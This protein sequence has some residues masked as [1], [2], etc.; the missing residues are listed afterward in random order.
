M[1]GVTGQIINRVGFG[2]F[3]KTSVV[4]KTFLGM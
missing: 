2:V 1:I 4:T 3:I